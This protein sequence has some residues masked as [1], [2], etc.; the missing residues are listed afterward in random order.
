MGLTPNQVN[1]IAKLPSGVAVVYQNNWVNPVLTMID[2]ARAISGF[3]RSRS[4]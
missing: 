2:K 4:V 1:E 3:R